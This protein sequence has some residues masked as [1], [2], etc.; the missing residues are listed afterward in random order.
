MLWSNVAKIRDILG[1]DAILI[2]RGDIDGSPCFI[3]AL[4]SSRWQLD[5]KQVLPKEL[6]EQDPGALA[7]SGPVGNSEESPLAIP[8]EDPGRVGN[9]DPA[10]LAI[11]E[12]E[13]T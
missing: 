11:S 2:R 4:P 5:G 8:A 6:F 10:A 9:S 12:S 13:E 3:I 7:I 1:K